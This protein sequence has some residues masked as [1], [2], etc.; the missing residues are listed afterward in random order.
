MSDHEAGKCEAVIRLEEAVE[1]I[2][3][4]QTRQNGSLEKA[5]DKMDVF[6]ENINKRLDTLMYWIMGAVLSAALSLLSS[7]LLLLRAQH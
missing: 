3:R 4:W 1:G 5:N 6:I 7:V 2:T